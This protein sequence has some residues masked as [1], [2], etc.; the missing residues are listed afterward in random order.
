MEPLSEAFV[1]KTW[2]EVAG[3]S[4]SRGH[5]EMLAMSKNQPDLLAFLTAFVDDLEQEVKEL[6]IYIAFVVYKMFLNASGNIPKISSKE[7]MTRYDENI[8]FLEKLE[9]AHERIFDR[10]AKLQVSK[11][12]Y[13]MKYVLEALMEDSEEDGIHL[14]E[15]DI[16]F[17]YILLKTEIEVLDKKAA[18]KH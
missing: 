9:G 14:S 15:E 7:I 2:Q 8:H 18:L 4:Q 1:E 10:I 12:P 16:G 5:K 17:L 13:V 11:Q 3:F 6:A